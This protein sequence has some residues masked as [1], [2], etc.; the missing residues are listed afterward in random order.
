MMRDRLFLS[1]IVF[2][3]LLAVPTTVQAAPLGDAWLY[4]NHGLYGFVY[5]ND[6]GKCTSHGTSISCHMTRF[7]EEA[8]RSGFK[9]VRGIRTKSALGS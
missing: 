9:W 5:P 8:K 7:G 1:A 3:L 6:R 4:G 2:S